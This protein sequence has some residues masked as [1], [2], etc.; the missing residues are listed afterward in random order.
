M[1]THL[2]EHEGGTGEDVDPRSDEVWEE[3]EENMKML[4]GMVG[5][6]AIEEGK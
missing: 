1:K 2:K 3:V 6:L 5:R 4:E